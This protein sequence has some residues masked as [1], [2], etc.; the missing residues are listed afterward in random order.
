[1][2]APFVIVA[3]LT[4]LASAKAISWIYNVATEL[5]QEKQR[6]E[7][8]RSDEI[9]AQIRAAGQQ[10]QDERES[11]LR[12]MS[13]KQ[14]RFLLD[15]IAARHMAV[16][17]LPEELDRLEKIIGQ[18]VADKTSSPYRKSALRREYARIE[19]AITRIRE[20]K[21]YLNKEEERIRSLLANEAFDELLELDT[22]ENLLPI[23]WLYAGKLVLVSMDELGPRLPRF[24][25]RISFGK[26]DA[27]QRAMALRY[28]DDIPVLIKSAHKHHEDLFYGCVARG[29]VYYHHIMPGEPIEFVVGRVVAGRIAVGAIWEG[30]VP[31]NL[32]LGQLKHPGVRLL[33][34]QKILVHPT[35]YDLCL[36][37]NP[38]DPKSRA[39]EVSE[40]NYQAR[41]SQSYQQLYLDVDEKLLDDISDG[42]FFDIEEPW[43]LLGYSV[44]TGE[45]SLAKASVRLVCVVREDEEMLEV[46]SVTQT[47][48]LLIGLDTPFRFTLIARPL[49]RAEQ[50]GWTY[51]VHEFL[52][53]C[54]QAA[55]DMNDSPG[56]LSQGRFYQRWEQVIAYQRD[57]EEN[58]SLE[59]PLA[60]TQREEDIL[61]V[62]RDWLPLELW[63]QF[64]LVSDKL[65][66]ILS[67]KSGLNPDHCVH[68][69]HWNAIRSDYVPSLRVERRNRPLY[70]QRE[71]SIA[72]EGNLSPLD[73][74]GAQM[75]R[76]LIRIP[77]VP[78]KRQ[79]QALDD[80]FQDR[81]VN[82]SLKN[83]LLAPENYLPDQESLSSP[84]EWSGS[85]DDSQKRVVQMALKERNIALIQGPPG[86]GKTTAIVEMLYQ[87]FSQRPNTRVLVVS[88]QNTAVDN[89]LVKFLKE[90]KSGC[91]SSAKAIRIGNPEKMNPEIQPLNFDS[92]YAAFLADL[93]ARAIEAAVRLPEVEGSL[94]YVWRADLKQAASS[95]VGQDEF[96]ITLLADHN[97][98]GATCVGLASNKG[99]VD[100]LQFDVAII[101]EAGR[102]TVPE[103]LIPILR[104]RKVILVG[105]HYQLPPSIA[106]LLREDE[107]TQALNFL[108]ENFLS[109]S[110]FE[111][112][113]ERLPAECRGVLDRQ[114][115]MAPAIGDLV[116]NLFYSR[117]GERILFNGLTESDFEESYLLDEC[118]YW[119]DVKGK[120]RQPRNSTSQENIREAEEIAAFLVDLAENSN[121]SEPPISV[122]VITPYGAQKVRI[123]QELS[124]KE[125]E[126]NSLNIEVNTVDAFQ[127]SEADV[128]CYST[129][130]TE[131]GLNFILDR[132]RLNVACSR[133]KRH[134]LFFGDSKYLTEWRTKGKNGEN[135]FPEILKHASTEKVRFK[136]RRK[137]YEL[138]G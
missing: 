89:A 125:G 93:D 20:Y 51:G 138:N 90:H 55:L 10:Q 12:Q 4:V 101:D 68:L 14:G 5:E 115:R 6:G 99:G 137:P 13:N 22:A 79:G 42:R 9:R 31:A 112:M 129:V 58:F 78:L 75:L 133:A 98:V 1:M 127:G 44:K 16:E 47:S 63:D 62:Q 130:R 65:R 120:Q 121:N 76:F 27:I 53:F 126:L 81:L 25:H 123:R 46:H 33:T 91:G 45:I 23:D 37:K 40:F 77:S 118:I 73:S 56:R 80:F 2:G 134:L 135:L 94:C 61:V 84:F 111:T 32:P 114:Y 64:D 132:K 57:Q 29:A 11:L 48:S 109:G 50:V 108:S 106:P 131:G 67:E 54:A 87:L 38:F 83:I 69:Q 15:A 7:R 59:L 88:Q 82:P 85:L 100:Q 102:A 24:N 107:A 110:F 70:T 104:S 117:E 36:T 92:Q 39:V 96:F 18:E 26:D 95:R 74:S 35:A 72:I 105:D 119:V 136:K 113:F 86:A 19:D 43:T 49:A 34:G 116:A 30:M 66:E 71:G 17:E 122:A 52:R 3:G 103:I 8:A 124:D 28:G 60:L 97:L 41:G 128:V 21:K